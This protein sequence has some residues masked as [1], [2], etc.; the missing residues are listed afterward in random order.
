MFVL[1]VSTPVSEIFFTVRRVERY[2]IKNACRSSCK[3]PVILV[4]IYRKLKVLGGISK[5]TLIPNYKKTHP[6]GAEVF[7][8]DRRTDGQT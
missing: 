2:V 4:R 1:I 8:A 3:V 5:N 7:R 6:V